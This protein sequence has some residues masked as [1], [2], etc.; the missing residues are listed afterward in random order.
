MIKASF[1]NGR[2]LLTINNIDYTNSMPYKEITN[3]FRTLGTLYPDWLNAHP[4]VNK[5]PV[6]SEDVFAAFLEA[7]HEND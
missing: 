5:L 7:D 3:H 2:W 4:W 1:T 6:R